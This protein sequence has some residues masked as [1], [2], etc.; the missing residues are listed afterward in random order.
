MALARDMRIGIIGLGR[1]GAASAEVFQ[2]SG[3]DVVGVFARSAGSKARAQQRVPN[4]P[5]LSLQEVATRADCIILTVSDDAIGAVAEELVSTD[6]LQSGNIVVHLSGRCGLEVLDSVRKMRAVPLACH[7]AMT[8]A[9]TP[10]DAD[11]LQ[12]SPFGITSRPEHREHAEGFVH[13]IGGT[14]TWIPE[15]KRTMYHAAM[16]FGANNLISLVAVAVQAMAAAGI[17]DSSSFLAPILRASLEN[18]IEL[19]PQAL[20]GPVRRGDVGTLRAHIDA[21]REV[22][23]D[24]IPGYIDFAQFTLGMALREELN[25][26][27]VLHKALAALQG[28]IT[29][30]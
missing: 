9:G 22:K 29:S 26:P 18:A 16:V 2:R 21:L 13:A 7:P 1:L 25:D 5:V 17:E 6:C 4:I 8:F 11:L 12:S 3:Y 14:S 24:L 30:G 28:A 19:G 23:P 27:V 10:H 20:T 15:D